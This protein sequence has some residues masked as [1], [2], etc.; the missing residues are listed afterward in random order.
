MRLPALNPD[1]LE[2]TGLSYPQD[3]YFNPNL[4]NH[5]L[6]TGSIPEAMDGRIKLSNAIKIAKSVVP[7]IDIEELYKSIALRMGGDHSATLQL[8]VYKEIFE[9][10]PD[11]QKYLIFYTTVFPDR[12]LARDTTRNVRRYKFGFRIFYPSTVA[13]YETAR[14]HASFSINVDL[15]EV[16]PTV[17]SLSDADKRTLRDMLREFDYS[18]IT[19]AF[20]TEETV[21]TTDRCVPYVVARMYEYATD[22]DMFKPKGPDEDFSIPTETLSP[23]R[24]KIHL[25]N[26]VKLTASYGADFTNF[27]YTE[28]P[29]P[30]NR[31][32]F[33]RVLNYSTNVLQLLP[34]TIKGPKEPTATL[35]GV[36]L[37]A[38]SEYFA[39]DVIDAQ[40]DLFFL[41]KS[42]S[43]VW[44]RFPNNFEMVTVPCS[45]KA[46]KRLWAEFF[47]KMDYRK[48]DTS[49]ETG[50]GMHVHIGSKVFEKST[51]HLN[52]FTWFF[53]NPANNDFIFAMSERPNK[54]DLSRYSAIA[55]VEQREGQ[56]YKTASQARHLNHGR[57]AIHF[58][59][60][61]VEVRIFKG[62]VSYAT[63]V[64]NLEFVDSVLEYTRVTSLAQL[65]LEH[66]L[67][68]L[69]ATPKNQYE[70]L[71]AFIAE[72]K[73]D[74][75]R[76]ANQLDVYLWGMRDEQAITEKL[77]KAPF[78]VTNAHLTI[79]NK[80]KGKGKRT[81]I[82]KDGK[83]H[84]V[85]KNY[86]VLAKLDMLAQK[87]QT[88]GST[89]LVSASL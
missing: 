22:F 76:L 31:K 57:G 75:I 1:T 56:Y 35:Y 30:S 5:Y 71:K 17:A 4:N 51:G 23:T 28:T 47:E 42:D 58:K 85:S 48:F 6:F 27:R 19:D 41:L 81:Y 11:D 69:A 53:I 46:H 84:C 18:L 21:F 3:D 15:T 54:T 64:K 55:H 49:K 59:G 68:W 82:L 83:V 80:R 36:E 87:K 20:N 79:L 74:P 67:S 16:S 45:L 86:G 12:E 32:R 29:D 65:S 9:A 44:G 77:N 78:P 70:L 24:L 13:Y 52:K 88:R 50:N 33:H 2:I 37:E 25:D 10:L 66:Y 26:G 8:P 73:L 89:T 14:T 40:K 60:P 34:Y 61:T 43:S 72:I 7:F 62:I 63:V 39:K 38:N